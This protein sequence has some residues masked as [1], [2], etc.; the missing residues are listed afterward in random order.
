MTAVNELLSRGANTEAKNTGGHTPLHLATLTTRLLAVKALLDVGA[1]C[2][3]I[4]NR[5]EHP[6]YV[7]VIKRSSEVSKYLLR[8]FY[9][10]FRRLP[11]H[12][13]LED[14]TWIGDPNSNDASSLCAALHRNALATDGVVEILEFLVERDPTLLRSGDPDGSRR[15]IPFS[16]VQSLVNMCKASARV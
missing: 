8:E 16:I 15:G 10:T 6:I 7:A 12:E 11:L 13:L 14:L 3:A 1:D 4:N 2:R 5:G 9:A